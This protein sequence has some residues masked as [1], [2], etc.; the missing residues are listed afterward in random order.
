[1]ASITASAESVTPAPRDAS[2]GYH[3]VLGPSDV[4]HVEALNHP[5]FNIKTPVGADGIIQLPY[6]GGVAAANLTVLELRERIAAEL[7]QKGVFSNV[8]LEVDVVSYAS[9]YVT[10]LGGVGAPGLLSMDRAYHLSEI[11]ARAGG[12]RDGSSNYVILRSVEGKERK[13]SVMDLATGDEKLDPF[14][15]PGDKI[16]VP[17][18]VFYVRGE[19]KTP[20]GYPLL[21]NMTLAMALARCGGLTDM[22]SDTRIKVI[23]NGFEVE[24]DGLNF[25]VLPDDVINVGESWF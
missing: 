4:V 15:E 12:V 19:V 8:A 17:T 20:G 2:G 6:I 13:L 23:R 25:K 10:V 18:E 7:K 11:L 21:L 14:V 22:G 16:Y 3:Y 24:P 1:M 5:D 9:R